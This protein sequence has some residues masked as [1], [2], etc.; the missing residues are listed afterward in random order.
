MIMKI[1]YITILFNILTSVY[2][3]FML[4]YSLNTYQLYEL[5]KRNYPNENLIHPIKYVC[6][7]HIFKFHD[8]NKSVT[9]LDLNYLMYLRKINNKMLFFTVIDNKSFKYLLNLYLVFLK[10]YNIKSL[11]TIVFYK[12]TLIK[13]KKY[14]ILCIYNEWPAFL[15][16]NTSILLKKKLWFLKYYYFYR[17]IKSGISLLF[18]DSDVLFINNC[19]NDLVNR[20]EDVILLKSQ[21]PM[22]QIFGN[23]GIVYNTKNFIFK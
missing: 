16:N 15:A 21:L 22:K 12:E 8:W 5:C 10:P 19:L 11:V 6:R 13:C 4:Y 9:S 17:L 23:S 1:I 14:K 7:N 2:F 3:F 20:N 18:I